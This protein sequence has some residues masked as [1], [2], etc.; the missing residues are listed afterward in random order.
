MPFQ[1]LNSNFMSGVLGLWDF[2]GDLTDTSGNG[3]DL[4]TQSGTVRFSELDGLRAVYLSVATVLERSSHEASLALK[5][6]MSIAMLVWGTIETPAGDQILV[7]FGDPATSGLAADNALYRLSLDQTTTVMKY[8]AEE[9]VSVSIGPHSFEVGFPLGGWHLVVMTRDA[10]GEVTLYLDGQVSGLVSSSLNVPQNGGSSV[11]TDIGLNFEGHIGGLAIANT[12]MSATDVA[13]QWAWVS[14]GHDFVRYYA[15]DPTLI[16][17]VRGFWEFEDDL[18]DSSGNGL[19]L[20]GSGLTSHDL[21]FATFHGKRC[22]WFEFG[23]EVK[24]VR[25][26]HDP[27]LRITKELTIHVLAVETYEDPGGLW[28]PQL[29]RFAGVGETE[30]TNQ[31]YSMEWVPVISEL[32]ELNYVAEQGSG[33]NITYSAQIGLPPFSW[34]LFTLTRDSAGEVTFYIDGEQAGL[35]SSGLALPTGGTEAVLSIGQDFTGWFGALLI[36]AHESTASEVAD[37]WAIVKGDA[38]SD[39]TDTVWYRMRAF[40]SNVV[41]D[42]VTWISEGAPDLVGTASPWSPGDLSDFVVLG[43]NAEAAT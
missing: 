26:Q 10:G 23:S 8:T 2:D 9:G 30:A 11:L 16:P 37:Q 36:A 24:A 27:A 32:T 19:D 13:A 17:N 7:S 25:P 39:N 3:F 5:G 1:N 22:V 33:T 4:T 6:A 40:E 38:S 28:D 14:N 43:T 34:H 12:E 41:N 15:P 29:V 42:Y 31:L 20:V 21:R 35:T 18:T